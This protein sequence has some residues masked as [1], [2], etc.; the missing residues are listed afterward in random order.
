[1]E[2]CSGNEWGTVCDDFWSSSDAIVV[3]MQLGL[4]SSGNYIHQTVIIIPQFDNNNGKQ[5]CHNGSI[6]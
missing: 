6:E 5:N 2:M 3:C 1:M 4:P